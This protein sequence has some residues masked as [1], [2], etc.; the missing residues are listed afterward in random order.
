MDER[1]AHLREMSICFKCCASTN[2]VARDCRALI[3]FRECDSDRHVAAM[4][5][6][7]APWSVEVPESKREQTMENTGE[8]TAEVTNKCTEI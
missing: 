4:H 2:H 1:K 7:P 3:K 6:G 8:D 5:P